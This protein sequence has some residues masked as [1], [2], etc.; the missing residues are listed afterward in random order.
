[1][2]V[3][4]KTEFAELENGR[5]RDA[6]RPSEIPLAGWRD[7][8]WRVWRE[9][10]QD[11]VLLIAAGATFYL[12]LALFPAL[13]AFV[14]L[15]GFVANPA[16]VADHVSHLGGLLPSAG[17][18][19]IRS[20]LEALASQ[21]QQA[22]GIGFLIGLAIALWSANNGVKALFDAMDIAY[23]ETEKRGFIKLNLISIA[24]TMG[25][26]LIAIGLILTVGVVPAVLAYLRLDAWTEALVAMGR[27]P[28][29]L[30]AILAGI[31]LIYRFGPSRRPPKWRWLSWGAVIATVVWI[32]A[33][34]T[35]SFYLR[36]FADYNA[37]YG[38]LGAV[39]G[40]MMWTWISVIILIIGAE[41]NAEIE[42]QTARDSTVGERP[43]PMGERGAVV[44]DTLGKTA[45]EL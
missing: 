18:D 45:G 25:A 30:V 10:G 1:M 36:N 24:F 28:V 40:L 2:A 7:I 33:S 20:Q 8:V 29:L 26:L 43:K 35:F 16:T 21:D 6:D 17:V 3:A 42:H 4:A 38:S 31:S 15:Y 13:A 32:G 44:A 12:L 39:I 22:L 34:W 23:E 11:R 27:W 19:I 5:G 41:I 37:T 14:S 9:V